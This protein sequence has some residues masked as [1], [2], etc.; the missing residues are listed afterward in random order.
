MRGFR[1]T[2]ARRSTRAGAGP[3]RHRLPRCDAH[4][5]AGDS[6]RAGVSLSTGRPIR[7]M[8]NHN[9]ATIVRAP[10]ENGAQWTFHSPPTRPSPPLR[11][12]RGAPRSRRRGSSSPRSAV[13]SSTPGSAAARWRPTIPAR[14]GWARCGRARRRHRRGA[15]RA[16]AGR[17]AA[18][19]R[20]PPRRRCSRGPRHRE[21]QRREPGPARRRAARPPAPPRGAALGSGPHPCG[22]DGAAGRRRRSHRKYDRRPRI[23]SCARRPHAVYPSEPC[24]IPAARASIRT[25]SSVGTPAR[26]SRTGAGSEASPS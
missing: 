21:A 16:P 4:C 19:A 17:P 5:P 18:A 23:R 10:C 12:R 25:G 11:R 3:L 15:E 20:L 7:L 24:L 22:G 8:A 1:R 26:T 13:A 14:L 2:S 6:D 9:L